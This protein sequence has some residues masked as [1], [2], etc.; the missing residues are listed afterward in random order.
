VSS[1]DSDQQQAA[2]E[3]GTERRA[4][5]VAAGAAFMAFLD[6][7]VVNVAFPDMEASFAGTSLA[8][9]SWVISGYAVL[10]A[11]LLTPAGR[12][13]DVMGRR[14]TFE[15]GVLAFTAASALCAIAPSVGVLIAARA[16]Q[17]AAAALMI[18]AA[19][20]LVLGFTPPER[21]IQAIGIWGAAGSLAAAAGPTLGG[22]LVDL[23]SWRLVFAINVPLGLTLALAAHRGLGEIKAGERRLPDL[24]GTAL[25]AVGLAALAV[26][27][28]KASDWGWGSPATLVS[29]IGGVA[30]AAVA[31]ARS[32]RHPRPAIETTLWRSPVFAAANLTAL[33]Y[34]VAVFVW[35][36]I[37]PLFVTAIWG[38]SV[39]EA[40]LAVSPGAISAAIAAVAVSRLATA[41][42]RR[43][44]TVL[45][46]LLLAGVGLWLYLALPEQPHFVTVWLPAGLLSGVAMGCIATAIAGAV[47]TS[48]PPDKFAAANGLALTA[49]QL[50]G[51]L[52]VAGG[53]AILTAGAL[54]LDSFRTV[55]LMCAIAAGVSAVA[56]LGLARPA[57]KPAAALAT[58]PGGAA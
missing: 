51:G 44:A 19:L 37:C 36:L 47:A 55:F 7:T 22:V 9:L 48:V 42:Q 33:F 49:R 5:A 12:L 11:A 46:S 18:P 56:A 39:L 34:G 54:D 21:R 26:G 35:L 24:L 45:S 13:A 25:L 40:G 29:L 6:V 15:I 1:A 28:S 43:A 2:E 17:G 57:A 53:A 3:R 31:L 23:S 52:G 30:L 50:G 27:L 8:E 14:R 4:L 32:F 16:V 41:E 10:F 58:E 20:G 38:Y